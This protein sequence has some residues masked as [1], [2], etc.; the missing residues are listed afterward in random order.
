MDNWFGSFGSGGGFHFYSDFSWLDAVMIVLTAAA[1]IAIAL[2]FNAVTLWIAEMVC[3]IL[4]FAGWLV[5]FLLGVL[6]LILIFRIL[7]R[8]RWY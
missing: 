8:P 2:H 1:G 3:R 6:F 7:F 4:L 5:F